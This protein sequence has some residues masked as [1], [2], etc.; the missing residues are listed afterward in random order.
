[1]YV[2]QDSSHELHASNHFNRIAGCLNIG[3]PYPKVR[4]ALMHEL[5]ISRMAA[6]KLVE[7]VMRVV[8]VSLKSIG[9]QPSVSGSLVLVYCF[10]WAK[11]FYHGA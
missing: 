2:Q 1:M 10:L 4:D 8:C 7:D 3:V 11:A 6:G 5:N 9:Y